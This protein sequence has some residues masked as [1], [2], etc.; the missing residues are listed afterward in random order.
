MAVCYATGPL[1][2]ARK[3]SELPPLGMTAACLVFAAVIYAPI[4]ALTWPAA[5]HPA[6]SSRRWPGSP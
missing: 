2:V 4:A 5:C 1:I 3:L 6:R